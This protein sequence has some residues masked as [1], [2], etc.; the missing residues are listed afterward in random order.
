MTNPTR[1]LL[2]I[3]TKSITAEATRATK[4]A[5]KAA[6]SAS[7][8]ATAY[9]STPQL[10]ASSPPLSTPPPYILLHHHK[11]PSLLQ[12]RQPGSFSYLAHHISSAIDA[13]ISLC[14]SQEARDR[15]LSLT[16]APLEADA[17]S[18]DDG[19]LMGSIINTR[20]LGQSDMGF[21][22]SL[23]LY[24]ELG[25]PLFRQN[26]KFNIQ[27][28]MDGCRW[29]LERF[30][31]TKE[32]LL[33][34]LIYHV[35]AR[36]EVFGNGV[37]NHEDS[38]N[39]IMHG[40]VPSELN[41]NFLD[42]A[43]INP[44]SVESSFVAMT[45]PE[46][47]DAVKMDGIM[48]LLLGRMVGSDDAS[49]PPLATARTVDE[50]DKLKEYYGTGGVV[51]LIKDDTK[52]MNVALLSARVEE[53]YPPSPSAEQTT[54]QKKVNDPEA[55]LEDDSLMSHCQSKNPEEDE[56]KAQ[57]VTQLEV[58]YELQQSSVND[59]GK[60][61]TQTSVMVGKFE[62]CLDGDP[63]GDELRWKLASYRPAIEYYNTF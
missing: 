61:R 39:K 48:R 14:V 1:A 35:D 24:Q 33:P 13:A 3:A 40:D 21:L 55:P 16:T 45:T 51:K 15:F 25:D 23:T 6:A 34:K 49:I 27:E 60:T 62:G 11:E 41:Y 7:A 22:K 32:E 56:S 5:A 8:S 63:N 46:A 50:I 20:V 59:E 28:F 54:L 19:G 38:K 52:V 44:D 26:S 10:P 30:H 37:E 17:N 42:I 2:F 43:A 31:R 29:A 57:V 9:A 18:E 4:D 47:L 53:I 36:R 58:L 12:Y